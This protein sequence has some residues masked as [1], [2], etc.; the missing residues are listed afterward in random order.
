MARVLPS[1]VRRIIEDHFPWARTLHPPNVATLSDGPAI[2]G[3]VELLEEIPEALLTLSTRG[4]CDF[5]WAVA[6]LRHLAKRLETAQVSAGGGWPWP[7]V[8]VNPTNAIT[9]LWLLLAD[10]PDEGIAATT[11][12]LNFIDEDELR[13]SVRSDASSSQEALDNGQWK[14]ATVLA[15]SAI[16][17]LLLF[18]IA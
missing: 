2:A 13:Q 17:A 11:A 18:C 16:E 6:G 14:A 9:S 12:E 3:L 4:R 10:C 8:G 7:T 15:G 5:T 1:D